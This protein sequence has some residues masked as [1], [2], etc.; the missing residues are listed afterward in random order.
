M[1]IVVA[2]GNAFSTDEKL[3]RSAKRADL[4]DGPHLGSGIIA[5]LR[6]EQVIIAAVIVAVIDIYS[7]DEAIVSVLM[8]TKRNVR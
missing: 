8:C 4:V 2:L 1:D 6:I 7:Y 3:R 5:N